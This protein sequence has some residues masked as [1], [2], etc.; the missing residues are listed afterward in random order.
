MYSEAYN[1]GV[2]GYGLSAKVFH[3]PLIEVEPQFKLYS[4]VQRS[5]K[6]E[7]DVAKDFPGIKIYRSTDEMIKDSA[8]DVVVVTIPPET[9]FSVTKLALEHGKHGMA[10]D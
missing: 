2:V 5:P 6:P 7:D 10:E 8:V 1:I 4:V 9:H 3:I